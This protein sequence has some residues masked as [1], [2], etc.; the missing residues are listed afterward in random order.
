MGIQTL[1]G[2]VLGTVNRRQTRDQALAGCA[3]CSSRPGSS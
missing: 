2:E 3:S 1:D